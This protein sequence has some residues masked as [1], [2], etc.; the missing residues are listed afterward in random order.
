ML[1]HSNSRKMLIVT[2]QTNFS[3][4]IPMYPGVLRLIYFASEKAATFVR[5]SFQSMF[6][7]IIKGKRTQFLIFDIVGNIRHIHIISVSNA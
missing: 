3:L 1:L 7:R 4:K 6:F 5:D 2:V